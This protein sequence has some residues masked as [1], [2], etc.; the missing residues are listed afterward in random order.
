MF[1]LEAK[2][3]TNPASNTLDVKVSFSQVQIPAEEARHFFLEN[4]EH[5]IRNVS[6]NTEPTS[7]DEVSQGCS[8]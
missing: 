2:G 3:T 6:S 7:S 8:F 1:C 5:A 4:T